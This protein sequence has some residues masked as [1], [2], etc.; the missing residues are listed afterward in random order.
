ME[1]TMKI[2]SI[3]LDDETIERFKAVAAS[4]P[5]Q[6]EAL[7]NLLNTYEMQ[8]AR[9]ELSG[10]ATD[11]SDFDSHL[12]AIQ[13][14]FLHILD[15]NQNTEERVKSE[16][17]QLLTSK[18]NQ[19]IEYQKRI[20]DLEAAVEDA[21]EQATTAGINADNIQQESERAIHELQDK[22]QKAEKRTSEVAE[23]AETAKALVESLKEQLAT[24]QE[25]IKSQKEKLSDM[26]ELEQRATRAEVGKRTA[27]QEVITLRKQIETEQKSAEQ[28]LEMANERSE[29]AIQ[30]AIVDEQRKAMEKTESLY[31]K[32]DELR[33]EIQNLKSEKS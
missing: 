13:S 15:I 30:K 2:R 23:S 32:I 11:I 8:S 12:K 6:S 7:A 28:A 31:A 22:L 21:Q 5:N 14:A 10:M 16:V 26:A 9:D 33:T 27:E 18:D 1:N 24:A 17:Q 20:K 25:T 29:V 4:F 19:I 3:R